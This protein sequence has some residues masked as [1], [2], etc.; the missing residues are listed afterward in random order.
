MGA[1][2]LYREGFI[3]PT[4]RSYE[5]IDA[6]TIANER[7]ITCVDFGDMPPPL[8]QDLDDSCPCGSDGSRDEGFPGTR[9]DFPAA[10]CRCHSHTVPCSPG[11]AACRTRGSPSHHQSPGCAALI[12]AM[13]LVGA[14]HGR[15][16]AFPVK[17]HRAHGALLR[18]HCR[19]GVGEHGTRIPSTDAASVGWASARLPA[20]AAIATVAIGIAWM[21]AA[22]FLSMPRDGGPRPTL[23]IA[24]ILHPCG[25]GCGMPQPLPQRRRCRGRG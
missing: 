20:D 17:P 15:D 13:D 8:P 18:T 12:Q 2:K 19:S 10:A 23:R 3:A 5:C 16:A 14:P 6:P 9:R 25:S 4:G 21:G 24:T 1:M 7:C 11:K 22:S